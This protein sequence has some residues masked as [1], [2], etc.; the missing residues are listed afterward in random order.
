LSKYNIKSQ[1]HAK[2]NFEQSQL[3]NSKQPHTG[4][5]KC[6]NVLASHTHTNTHSHPHPH[7]HTPT[8]TPTPTLTHTHIHTN[9][10]T[11]IHRNGNES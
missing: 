1:K 3:A 11:H 2:A 7:T 6:F 4:P 8:H 10:Q 9:T 5:V